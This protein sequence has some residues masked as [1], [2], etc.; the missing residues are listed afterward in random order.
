M[1]TK[2]FVSAYACEPGLGSEIGVGWHWVLEMSK[3]YDL[4]VL[5]RESNRERIENWRANHPDSPDIKFIYFD[6]P[7]WAR[8]W[9]KGLR[10]V[11]T[12]YNLWTRLSNPLVKKTMKENDIKVFHHVTYGNALWQVSKYG[13][14]QNFIWGPIGGLETIPEEYSRHFDFKS[15]MI[16]KVRRILV[17]GA[18]KS[19]SLK[20]RCK[21]ASLIL[22]KTEETRNLLP[23]DDKSKAILFT[24]VATENL[25]LSDN[26]V[27]HSSN[28]TSLQLLC[29]GHLDAWRG[30]DLAILAVASALKKNCVSDLKLKIVGKGPDLNRLKKLVRENNLE[31]SVSFLGQVSKSEYLRLMKNSDIVL[32]PSLKEGSVTVSF[33]AMTMGKPLIALDTGGYTKYFKPEYSVVIPKEGRKI[34]IRN[35][36]DAIIKLAQ[37][38]LREKMGLAAIEASKEFTWQNHG[39]EIF[40]VI[41]E[42]I[43]TEAF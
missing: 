31:S 12:Y 32:N 19:I 42:R 2:I 7:K 36:T 17:S 29:V 22:C 20:K 18:I 9:K 28:L 38:K 24:D 10:G 26:T 23:L 6:L 41:S 3:Y 15:R 39:K 14:A 27:S 1:K 40:K 5:T 4:W 13:S 25:F 35:L 33:D 21:K 30:F 37:P 34:I 16:E 8:K 43:G 11:R